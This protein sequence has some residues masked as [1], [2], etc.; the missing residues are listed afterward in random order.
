VRAQDLVIQRWLVRGPVPSENDSLRVARDYLGGNETTALPTV[1]DEG[2]IEVGSDP[3]GR[4]DLNEVFA[5]ESTA[6][7]AAYAHTYVFAPEDRT[8]LLVADSDDDLVA[9]VNGQRVWLNIVARGLGRGDAD[10]PGTAHPPEHHRQ[11]GPDE[12]PAHPRLHQEQ[13]PQL[14]Q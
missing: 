7:T 2:W 1:G 14:T 6:W 10:A 13:A 9:F 5:G 4:L 12:G 3:F 11:H 8:V